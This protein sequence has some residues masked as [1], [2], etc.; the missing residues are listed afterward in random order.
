M[1]H[2]HHQI[3]AALLALLSLSTISAQAAER[4]VGQ[5]PTATNEVRALSPAQ[6]TAIRGISRNVLAA[7]KS[8]GQDSE[9]VAQLSR[10]RASV[11]ALIAADIQPVSITVAGEE[12]S[13]Q[14]S[15]RDKIVRLREV[16]GGEAHAL[17]AQ[18]RSR[19]ELKAARA[20]GR[21][22]ESTHSAGLPIDEQRARLF[23]RWANKLD[24]AINADGGDRLMK[25]NE[26]RQQLQATLGRVT[27][28]P[29]THGTPTMQA[30]PAGFVPPHSSGLNNVDSSGTAKK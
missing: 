30:M 17:V 18:L 26:L 1:N 6:I 3:W 12:S 25:L 11:D 13:D 29:L 15:T 27:E 4:T 28:A 20:R 8:G 10:L 7:K 16:A 9:D 14:R 5:A 22:E 2:H 19:S 23:E 21:A 24:S